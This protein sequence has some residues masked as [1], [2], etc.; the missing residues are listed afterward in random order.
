MRLFAEDTTSPQQI[1]RECCNPW[2]LSRAVRDPLPLRASR[3]RTVSAPLDHMRP[4]TLRAHFTSYTP[5]SL[6]ILHGP[7]DLCASPSALRAHTLL[8]TCMLFAFVP[9]FTLHASSLLTFPAHYPCIAPSA[10][11]RLRDQRILRSQRS[12]LSHCAVHDLT[13]LTAFSPSALTHFH[14]FLL[15]H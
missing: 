7:C 10:V 4:R 9:A 1:L 13:A 11:S 2:V 3:R 6:C 8:M 5:R 12:H 14:P 15:V